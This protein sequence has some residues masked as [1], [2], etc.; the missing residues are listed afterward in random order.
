MQKPRRI[1]V[2]ANQLYG[3]IRELRVGKKK[4]LFGQDKK[5]P[6]SPSRDFKQVRED[7]AEKRA[8]TLSRSRSTITLQPTQRP[9]H[10]GSERI[11]EVNRVND[12]TME[13]ERM[14]RGG[15][16]GDRESRRRFQRAVASVKKKKKVIKGQEAEHRRTF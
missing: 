8:P 5:I 4:K 14:T 11:P 1:I 7:T 2:H 13:T 15:G 3:R 16:G 9:F 6:R 10:G 12:E